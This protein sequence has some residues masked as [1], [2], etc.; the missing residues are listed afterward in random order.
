[1][2]KTAAHHTTTAHETSTVH[3]TSTIAHTSSVHTSS[4]IPS[5][6]RTGLPS[7]GTL[8]P[9]FGSSNPVTPPVTPPALCLDGSAYPGPNNQCLMAFPENLTYASG[10][11]YTQYLLTQQQPKF[12]LEAVAQLVDERLDPIISPGAPFSQ[13]SHTVFGGSMF[14]AAM[15]YEQTQQADCSSISVQSDKSNYWMPSIY[16]SLVKGSQ[17]SASYSN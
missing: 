17:C 9:G 5:T 7:K 16:V 11:N 6:T 10:G 2:G 1:M 8:K 14:S 3:K 12:H 15:T 4:H 13:H